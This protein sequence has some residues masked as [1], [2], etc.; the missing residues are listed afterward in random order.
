MFWAFLFQRGSGV[1]KDM[2]KVLVERPRI[3]GKWDRPRKTGKYK[4]KFEET[5]PKQESMRRR[6]KDLKMLNENLQPLKRFLQKAAGRKWD[7]VFSEIC[8]NISLSSATQKHIR[9]H[10]PDFVFTNVHLVP[11]G[12]I[13]RVYRIYSH[14]GRLLELDKGQLYVDPRTGYLRA[15][16]WGM[17]R[18]ERMHQWYRQYSEL[19][20]KFP[21]KM[22]SQKLL[23]LRKL[24]SG[25]IGQ[26]ENGDLVKVSH[27]HV[28][29]KLLTNK[30]IPAYVRADIGAAV[31]SIGLSGITR[32]FETNLEYGSSEHP[33]WKEY[34]RQLDRRIQSE[35]AYK[36]RMLAEENKKA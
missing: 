18:K 4:H 20:P 35:E 33:Y 34:R 17:S 14:V 7:A 13:F 2:K 24:F 10:I 29:G 25:D 31:W 28:T 19:K 27:D 6:H 32:F 3:G 11:D 30:L 23:E 26:L 5:A 9:D 21:F 12:K 22:S 1:R 36:K 15:Y 16:K 8:E